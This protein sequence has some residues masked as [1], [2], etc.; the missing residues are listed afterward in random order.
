LNKAI[1]PKLWDLREA[2]LG[3]NVCSATAIIHSNIDRMVPSLFE[4]KNIVLSQ[5]FVTRY[6]KKE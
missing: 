5:S 1:A 4:D 6:L 3:V 2:G